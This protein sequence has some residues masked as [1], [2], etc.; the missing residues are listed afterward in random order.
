MRSLYF[1][2]ILLISLAAC[3]NN[4]TPGHQA[5]SSKTAT[6]TAP[7]APRLTGTF[8]GTI[9]CADCPG[10]DYQISLYD[11]HTFSELTAYQGRGGGIATVSNGSWK[12]LNDSIVLIRK[13]T[14]SSSFLAAAGK[15][16]LLDRAGKRIEGVLAS[17]YELKP[18]EGG[19]RRSI[20]A[21]KSKA[22]ITFTAS[23]NEPFWTLDLDK[24]SIHY[25]SA[26]GDSILAALPAPRPNTDTLKVYTTPAI[27]V[28]IRNTAC[29]DDMSGVMRP[30]TVEVKIKDHTYRGCGE[31][32]MHN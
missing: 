24:K 21:E 8:Q 18:V 6:T 22:G 5:D 20:N 15:L 27:T 12:Q 11:D 17:N 2:A 23:G 28:S 7:A 14:D 32:L 4:T 31:H 29:S 19:D 16:I 13:K 10:I 1:S 3:N 25:K 30:N 9:P 26:N